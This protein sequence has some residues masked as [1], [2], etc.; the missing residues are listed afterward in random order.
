MGH[1]VLHHRIQ[2]FQCGRI[3]DRTDNSHDPPIHAGYGI[4]LEMHSH[5][6]RINYT[7]LFVYACSSQGPGNRLVQFPARKNLYDAAPFRLLLSDPE[8]IFGGPVEHYDSAIRI[9]NHDARGNVPEN[10]FQLAPLRGC[11]CRTDVNLLSKEIKVPNQGVKFLNNGARY[12]AI[13]ITAR[14]SLGR[15]PA[16]F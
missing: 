4:R 13:T 7:N 5:S 8:Y 10:G 15:L 16:T 14:Q 1:E 12:T 6:P 9:G 3:L 2:P 11:F